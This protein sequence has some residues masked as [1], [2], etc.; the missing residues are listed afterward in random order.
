MISGRALLLRSWLEGGAVTA[1]AIYDQVHNCRE[2]GRRAQLATKDSC[3]GR[4][5]VV[6]LTKIK[7]HMAFLLDNY[8]K[9]ECWLKVFRGFPRVLHVTTTTGTSSKIIRNLGG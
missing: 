5:N 9:S 3:S 8:D 6:A 4:H 7:S 1:R 2:H